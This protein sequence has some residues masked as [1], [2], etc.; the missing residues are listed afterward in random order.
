M[1]ITGSGTPLAR[2]GLA[3]PGVLVRHGAIALQFDVG[4]AT[5][6]RLAENGFDLKDLT[7][8]FVT[9]HHSDHMVGLADLL[10]TRW[11]S[12]IARRG[13]EPLPIFVPDGEAGRIAA[14]VLDVWRNEI[15]A[16]AI[17]TGRVDR[18]YPDVRPFRAGDE[19]AVVFEADTVAVSVVSVEHQPIT[20]AVAFRVDTPR[21]SVVVS[22]DTRVCATVEQLATGASVLVHEA[23]RRDGVAGILSDPD[24]IAAYHADTHELGAMAARCG[25]DTLVLTHLIPPV[26]REEDKAPF[27]ADIRGAGYEGELIV[28]DDLSTVTL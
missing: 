22:G 16:R 5:V 6:L 28:A 8:V 18:P 9:H 1:T 13:Q 26:R 17:H 3:G 11:L 2:P 15:E 10:M 14:R 12:D 21:G 25:V 23:F 7:A 19:P 27:V 4:R 24:A 20:P